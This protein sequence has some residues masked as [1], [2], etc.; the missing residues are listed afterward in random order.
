MNK[1]KEKTFELYVWKL[2]EEENWT[3]RIHF[4]PLMTLAC[5]RMLLKHIAEGKEAEKYKDILRKTRKFKQE[6]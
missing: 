3:E 5:R 1:K 4:R 6:G 2:I